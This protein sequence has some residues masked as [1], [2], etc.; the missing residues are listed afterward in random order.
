MRVP[1]LFLVDPP[2]AVGNL[3]HAVDG[4][5]N[6]FHGLY[7]A[8]NAEAKGAFD[9]YANPI[10]GFV[11]WVRNARHHNKANR[12]RS[13]YR[14]ARTEENE[15]NYI[16]VDFA[17]GEKEE[18]GA[19]AEHYVSWKDIC[20][21]FEAQSQKY[22]ASVE[23]YRAGLSA[24]EMEAWC[25]DHGYSERQIYVNLIPILA[26]AGSACTGAIANYITPE[27]VE[28]EAFLNIFQNVQAADFTKISYSELTSKVFWPI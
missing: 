11:L 15:T 19:F 4:I 27:S 3:D 7:D 14:C 23:A 9:F 22:P 10:A 21:I 28:A 25:K 13:V 20:L 18:G 26:A 2:E 6:A 1:G 5:L 16:L 8:V 12:V 17:A 24:D